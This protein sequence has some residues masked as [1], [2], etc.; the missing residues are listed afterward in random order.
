MRFTELGSALNRYGPA[1]EASSRC[2]LVSTAAEDLLSLVDFWLRRPWMSAG[3]RVLVT[4]WPSLTLSSASDVINQTM[5]R[6]QLGLSASVVAGRFSGPLVRST[7]R[8]L[9][10]DLSAVSQRRFAGSF[11]SR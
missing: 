8:A 6:R 11:R 2:C 9:A 3:G 4:K 10:L 7:R 5:G 1:T